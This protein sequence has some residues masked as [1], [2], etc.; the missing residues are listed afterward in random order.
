MSKELYWLVLTA[1]MTGR[2]WVPYILDRIMVRGV[3][4]ASAN[5]SP[6]DKPQAAWAQRM[7]AAHANTVENLGVRAARSDRAGAQHPHGLDRVRLRAVLLVPADLRRGLYRRHSGAAHAGLRRRLGR[8]DDAGAGDFRNDVSVSL[9][10]HPEE[11]RQRVRAKRGPMTASAMRLEGGPRVAAHGSRR[12]LR[13]LL[14]MRLNELLPASRKQRDLL[15]PRCFGKAEHQVHVL[16][17][18]A[19]RALDQVV[20]RRDHDRASRQ[21]ILGDADEGHVG[22]ADVAGLR[23]LPERQHMHERLLRVIL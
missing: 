1:A 3:M 20:E 8:T 9:G 13:V 2:L 22:A 14:T 11:Y 15:Q 5:P 19:R 10:P 18:L 12:T 16:H 4:G 17:G 23:C 7:I 21:P 6:A